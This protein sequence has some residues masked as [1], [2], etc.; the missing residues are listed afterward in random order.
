MTSYVLSHR[1]LADIE[2]IWDYTERRWDAD[3]AER[4]SRVLKE[5]IEQVVRDSRRGRPC[6]H[7]RPGYRKYPIGSHVLFFRV[8]EERIEIVRILHQRMDFERHL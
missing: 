6:D 4:Y 7:I 3:Q 1:A 8:L 5:G 2:E